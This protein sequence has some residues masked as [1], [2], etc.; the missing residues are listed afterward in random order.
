MTSSVE[1]DHVSLRR[2][3]ALLKSAR[4]RCG[5]TLIQVEQATSAPL[6]SST[7]SLLERAQ[8]PWPSPRQLAELARLY[9]IDYVELLD[10]AGYL[11]PDL[12]NAVDL[13]ELSWLPV[14]SLRRLSAAQRRH[15]V[16]YVDLLLEDDV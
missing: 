16:R 8:L 12:V 4:E 13:D 9:E 15:L 6:S 5:M 3:G 1:G 14:A 11:P 2:L 7:A 10:L